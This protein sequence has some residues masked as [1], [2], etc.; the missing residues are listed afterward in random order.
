MYSTLLFKYTLNYMSNYPIFTADYMAISTYA[1]TLLGSSDNII[2]VGALMN[3]PYRSNVHSWHYN[4]P[5]NIGGL[6]PICCTQ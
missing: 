3:N 4:N 1:M 2:H 6:N 5:L